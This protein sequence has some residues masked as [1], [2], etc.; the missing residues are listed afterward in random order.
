MKIRTKLAWIFVLLL[1]FG[2]NGIS[3]YS[4]VFIHNYL[5]KQGVKQIERDADW[6]ALTIENLDKGIASSAI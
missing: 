2:I 6:V 1:M 3:S 5:L 4:I